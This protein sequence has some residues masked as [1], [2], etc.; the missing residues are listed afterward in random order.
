LEKRRWLRSFGST[1]ALEQSM[2][3][4]GK[5]PGAPDEGGNQMSSGERR[6]SDV[7][8][9]EEAIRCHQGRGGNQMSSGKRTCA[10]PESTSAC[11]CGSNTKDVIT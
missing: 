1:A 11:G 10:R 2:L 4:P 5:R 8:R 3:P 6:Q 9:E 7:I